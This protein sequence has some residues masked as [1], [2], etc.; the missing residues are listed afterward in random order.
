[1]HDDDGETHLPQRH[2]RMAGCCCMI[3]TANRLDGVAALIARGKAGMAAMALRTMANELR[4]G[5]VG[6]LMAD[7]EQR[8]K[9]KLGRAVRAYR[10]SPG[11]GDV[12]VEGSAAVMKLGGRARKKLTD[13]VVM[14]LRDR[15][16][17]HG[18]AREVLGLGPANFDRV[19]AGTLELS[20][21]LR[22][23]LKKALG[24]D[25]IPN[26]G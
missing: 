6:E 18:L 7:T 3:C 16:E 5:A 2:A 11:A 24:G 22:R 20:P 13:E 19:L 14:Q 12:V 15:P 23:R 25:I 10:M 21:H 1:M 17:L 26:V 8:P 4:H 9:P